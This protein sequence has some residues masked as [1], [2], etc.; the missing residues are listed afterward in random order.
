MDNN[1]FLS[2]L[3]RLRTDKD[4]TQ[5]DLADALALS[6]QAVS[7]YETGQRAPDLKTLIEIASYFKV[8]TDFL[9]GLADYHKPEFKV[10][11]EKT[12]LSKQ[13]VEVLAALDDDCKD[14]VNLLIS[15]PEFLNLINL[16]SA[17]AI[18]NLTNK[19]FIDK[20]QK[21]VDFCKKQAELGK[22]VQEMEGFLEELLTEATTILQTTS[23]TNINIIEEVALNKL[24][25][26]VEII[27]IEIKNAHRN[28]TIEDTSKSMENSTI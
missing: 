2:N 7:N 12:G 13:S 24:K 18:A 20:S 22:P 14:S 19:A 23:N 28:K 11:A 10:I 4:M 3:K 17:Y 25:N 8:S 9:L 1:G 26:S 16:L 6:K 5:T 21:Y 15:S 27:A